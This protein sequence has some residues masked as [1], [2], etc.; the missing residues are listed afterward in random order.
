MSLAAAIGAEPR[1]DLLWEHTTCATP[2]WIA[3]RTAPANPPTAAR[4]PKA[5]V[6]TKAIVP[7]IPILKKITVRVLDINEGHKKNNSSWNL[8]N[9]S[10]PKTLIAT[11]QTRRERRDGWRNCRYFLIDS[12]IERLGWRS[13]SQESKPIPCYCNKT[14]SGRHFSHPEG[15]SVHGTR[16][17]TMVVLVRHLHKILPRLW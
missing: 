12:V 15:Y 7:G 6:K 9:L 11:R 14:A 2:F 16:Y 8:R 3:I 1:P 10:P 17:R 13:D 5:E 4:G